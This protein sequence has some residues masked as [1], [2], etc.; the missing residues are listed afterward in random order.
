MVA[1]VCVLGAAGAAGCASSGAAPPSIA[2]IGNDEAKTSTR[3][4]AIRA[5]WDLAGEDAAQRDSVRETLKSVAW[6]RS[7]YWEIRVEA[8]RALLADVPNEADTRSM[9]GFMLPTETHWQMIELIS[10]ESGVRG[11]D[12]LTLPLVMSWSR[13]VKQPTDENRPE[14]AALIALHPDVGPTDVVFDAFMGRVADPLGEPA[15]ERDRRDAWSLLQ[16]IDAGAERTRELLASAESNEDDPVVRALISAARDL[17]VVPQT[18]EQVDWVVALRRP[19]HGAF[20][21]RTTSALGELSD[22]SRRG[23]ELRHAGSLAWASEHR[24]AW[25]EASGEQLVTMIR[26]E[27]RGVQRFLRESGAG[28]RGGAAESIR[29]W[30]DKLVWADLLAIRIA[31]EALAQPEVVEAVFAQADRDHGDTSSEHGGLIEASPSGDLR[32]RGFEPRATQRF[33][34]RRFVAPSEMIEASTESIFHYHFHVNRWSNRQYAGPSRD[35]V[36]YA[37][38]FGRNCIVF[39]SINEDRINADYFQPNGAVID[40]GAIERPAP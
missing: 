31:I 40:L 22:E 32:S 1:W 6:K 21:T 19:E 2:D 39:T 15:R 10:E 24:S 23:F 33:G 25:V 38:R 4:R 7:L 29:G 3:V 27:Q 5:S 34:D 14:R 11:W 26:E 17:G 13:P 36:A 37:E 28:N 8:V 9:L 18:S 30:E 20:W 12:E 35:D 16:R